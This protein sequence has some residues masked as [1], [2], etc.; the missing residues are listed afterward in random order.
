MDSSDPW[1]SMQ[2]L[3]D[4]NEFYQAEKRAPH[5]TSDEEF[6]R[7]VRRS[8][9][10]TNSVDFVAAAFAI[11]APGCR[12]RPHLQR[13]MLRAPIRAA[14]ASGVD[15]P[16]SIMSWGV[17]CADTNDRLYLRSTPDGVAWL[18]QE[19]PSLENV[20]KEIVAETL[21]WVAAGFPGDDLW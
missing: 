10:G 8:F 4:L 9:W 11:V 3:R 17:R 2:Q 16:K 18:A 21:A 15:D 5:A 7:A 14:V 6:L 12:L 1:S 13:K 20:V 19:F